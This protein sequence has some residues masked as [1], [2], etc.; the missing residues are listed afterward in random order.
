LPA[1]PRTPSFPPS[2]GGEESRNLICESARRH[3]PAFPSFSAS[4]E[5][6][7]LTRIEWPA[8]THPKHPPE[9]HSSAKAMLCHTLKTHLCKLR[10]HARATNLEHPVAIIPATTSWHS[11]STPPPRRPGRTKM[12]PL[13]SVK[14]S[15]LGATAKDLCIERQIF[16]FVGTDGEV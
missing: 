7:Q 2:E 8:A 14:G 12:F 13:F 4:A 3:A 6:L 10:Y 9:G 16:L 1:L 15:Y 5:V 11:L